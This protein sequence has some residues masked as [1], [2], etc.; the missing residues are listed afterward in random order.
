MNIAEFF[1]S[2]R[3]ITLVLTF[4]LLGG[5]LNAYQGMSRLEDPE[6]TIKDALVITPYP[7]ASAA[8]VEE[9]VTD[10]L[11]LAIQQLAQ[12]D[13]ITSK[14]DRGLSTITVT[15]KDKY[16]KETLPQ[17]WDELRR[18]VG[19]AQTGLPPGAGPSVVVDDYGDVFG[20]FFAVYGDEYSYAELKE[21][22][23]L[24]RRELVLVE[25]VAKVETYGELTEA[26]FVELERDRMSQ[27]GI[28]ESVIIDELR[29]KN[30][31]S[32][33]GRVE[34][35]TE[36]I[37]INPGGEL[38]SV[39]QF[40]SILLSGQGEQQIFLRDVA[41]VYRGYLEPPGNVIRYD[42][43]PAIAVGI[44][45]VSG[46]NVV[47][48]GEA[49][50]ARMLE[51]LPEIPL[52]IEL[53]II[54]LQ[55]QAVTQ[56]IS[57]FVNSLL[58]AVGIVI[59]V[60]LFFMGLRS[61]L[62]IGFILVLT[63]AG[64]FIFLSPMNV[65]LERISLGALIIALGMLVDNAIVIVDGM[66]IRLQKGEDATAAA[67]AVVSQSALPLLG[68]TIIAILA[69]AAIGTSQ[70]S[71]GE[72][73][74]SLF[75]VVMVSLLLSWVTA[76]A[77]TPLL[78]VMFLKAPTAGA[79]QGE[80]PYGGR[81]YALFKGFLQGCIRL[82]WATLGAVVGV[83][84]LALYGFGSVE[85]AFFP[86]STR[87]QLMVDVWLP[88]GTHIDETIRTV[89]EIEEHVL[90]QEGVTHVTSLVGKG[91]LRFLLTYTPEKLNSAYAQLL[92]DVDDSSRLDALITEFEAHLAEAHPDALCYA[93]RFQLGPGSTGKIQ[94]RFSGPDADILRKLAARAQ[95]ILHGDPDTKSIRT[96]WRQRVKVI[97]PQIAEEQANLNGIQRPDIAQALLRGF[98]GQR[99]GGYRER[100]LLLPIVMRAAEGERSNV[101]SMKNLQIW[102]PAAGAM[103]PLRQVVSGFETTFEDEIIERR[104]RRRTI[105]VFADPVAG[106]A[107]KLFARVR[108]KIEEIELPD[109][110]GLKWGGEYE[111]S[112]KAQGAL[113]G[114]I[115][116]FLMVMVLVTIMLFN[117]LR[118]PLI[119]WLCVPLALIGVTVGLLGTG[120][121]FGFMAILGF[122]SLSGMLIKNAVVLIDEI[123]LQ[124]GEGKPLLAAILDSAVSRLRPV[125]MAASTTA[126]GMI[127][128]LVDAFFV[129]MAV[130]IIAGLLFATVLTMVVVPVL[131]AVFFGASE[132]EASASGQAG[133]S[134]LGQTP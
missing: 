118:Q 63:I 121:A 9:E 22:V 129:S 40:E 75:Q 89:T 77:V 23:D 5:G 131:Y 107:S 115:P 113:L 12:L 60:L 19:D 82:R 100:D 83:F 58:Q 91:G 127:P 88:Q 29:Q 36:F 52:G 69:F 50:R 7:G 78:G 3:T 39:A 126:L 28:P 102:S 8:E 14:S 72:F 76:V 65:A 112:A 45:T 92:V 123:N 33:A 104:D 73:C 110:Y 95:A 41:R 62:L 68:A 30:L 38:R 79:G 114:S 98:E 97:R 20:V 42:G 134:D 96:D 59:V 128:L 18:K 80:D 27:L 132:A 90:E 66:L 37:T 55:S 125:A 130:T 108:P 117:S 61:G 70:D 57:G 4:V 94:A 49:L 93:S 54:S 86:P 53:G 35:G 43:K 32:D 119:I 48:M 124:S 99:I 34:V 16:D 81:F 116:L 105:T 85:Q 15:I 26:I 122:L 44:S 31:V 109:G 10:E 24:L 11:E 120:Q 87:P 17:V 2:R 13:E 111:D 74:R 51:L 56:A 103:I 71:T 46:G 84:A 67:S 133:G 6:F 101:A 21:V 1:I 25:D 106:P 64:S 47:N